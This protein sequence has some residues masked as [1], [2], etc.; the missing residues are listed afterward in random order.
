MVPLAF[1]HTRS[2]TPDSDYFVPMTGKIEVNMSWDR[3]T[4]S[5][6]CEANTAF[7]FAYVRVS[8]P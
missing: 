6:I 1:P 2:V 8:F 4:V 5:E 7:C 3:V